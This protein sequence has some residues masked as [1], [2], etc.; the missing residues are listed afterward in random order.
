[1]ID[2]FSSGVENMDP[3]WM[4]SMAMLRRFSD[5]LYDQRI[6]ENIRK[7]VY[8]QTVSLETVYSIA[9]ECRQTGPPL[10]VSTR[11]PGVSRSA[12]ILKQ[13]CMSVYTQ[14]MRPNNFNTQAKSL[15]G[16]GPASAADKYFKSVDPKDQASSVYKHL[17]R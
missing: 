13:L 11:P 9:G 4:P 3:A 12:H 2:P 15:T 14:A 16:F 17:Y 7:S 10:S 8:L 1:M 6:P 5:I